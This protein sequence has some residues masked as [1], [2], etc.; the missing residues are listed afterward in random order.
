MMEQELKPTLIHSMVDI[1]KQVTYW[2]DSAKEDWAVAFE[3]VDGGRQRYGL[4]FAHLALEKLLKAL[5][6]RKTHE[7]APKIHNLVRL[8]DLA[9]LQPSSE[10]RDTL[11]E[12]NAFHLEGRYPE[13][14]TPPPTAEEARGYMTRAEGVFQW[15]MTQ[16]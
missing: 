12:M 16:L 9:G 11:A 3:L 15:L 5:V 1:A 14:L 4:F 8:A 10:Q 2:R 6:C 13:S 7:L